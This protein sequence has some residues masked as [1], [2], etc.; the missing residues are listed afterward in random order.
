MRARCFCA[1]SGFWDCLEKGFTGKDGV[2]RVPTTVKTV[3]FAVT[4]CHAR[5]RPRMV[6]EHF[7]DRKPHPATRFADFVVSDL[8]DGPVPDSSAIN[9]T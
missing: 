9:R 6:D 1:G 4:R 5:T 8:G 7:V 3:V 2:R